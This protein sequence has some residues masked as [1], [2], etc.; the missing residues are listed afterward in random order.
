MKKASIQTLAKHIA[1]EVT[2]LQLDPAEVSIAFYLAQTYLEA[3]HHSERVPP[4]TPTTIQP[5]TE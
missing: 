3:H 2:R 5:Q 1:S 4:A